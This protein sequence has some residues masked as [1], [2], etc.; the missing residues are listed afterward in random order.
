M[1]NCRPFLFSGFSGFL[2]TF[3]VAS[4]EWAC[5]S[6]RRGRSGAA[7]PLAGLLSDPRRPRYLAEMGDGRPETGTK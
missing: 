5:P 7:H 3:S 6:G 4:D 1:I 2:L